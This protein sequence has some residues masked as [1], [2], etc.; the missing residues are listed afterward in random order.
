MNF[1]KNTKY[2]LTIKV[3]NKQ[4]VINATFDK[5]ES[6]VTLTFIREQ[7]VVS[8]RKVRGSYLRMEFD[9]ILNAQFPIYDFFIQPKVTNTI[10]IPLPLIVSFKEL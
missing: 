10:S 8:Y 7:P 5:N 6:D 3:G 2:H 4:E 9:K 1:K